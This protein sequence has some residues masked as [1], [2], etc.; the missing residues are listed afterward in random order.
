MFLE[1][2]LIRYKRLKLEFNKVIFL[3]LSVKQL[4]FSNSSKNIHFTGSINLLPS[5]M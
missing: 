3:S 2:F 4:V 1:N 5:D